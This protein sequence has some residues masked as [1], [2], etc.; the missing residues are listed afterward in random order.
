L[1][2]VLFTVDGSLFAL[3]ETEKEYINLCSHSPI[4]LL[5]KSGEKR[6]LIWVGLFLDRDDFSKKHAA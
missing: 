4:L 1:L 6:P 2:A 5:R 3:D